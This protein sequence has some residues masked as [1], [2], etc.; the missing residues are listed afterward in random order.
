[1]LKTFVFLALAAA[2]A[3]AAALYGV[4]QRTRQLEDHADHVAGE[5]RDLERE[6]NVLRAERAYLLR[7]ERLEPLARG[8]GLRPVTGD[9]F[10]TAEA[11]RRRN[12]N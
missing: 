1:M 2:L 6:I 8:L 4:G 12:R 11:L 10:A 3:S 7:P 9:Q 5:I